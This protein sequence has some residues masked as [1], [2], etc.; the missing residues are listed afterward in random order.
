[1]NIRLAMLMSIAVMPAVAAAQAPAQTPAQKEAA[2]PQERMYGHQLMTDA[3]RAEYRAKMWAMKTNEER[4]AFRLEHHKKMQE[5][6]KKRGVT[7]P[8]S[9]PPRGMGQGMRQGPG[10][11]GQP[12][13][14]QR[15]N[16]PPK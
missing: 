9:P 14:G 8:D 3:E 11:G 16:P 1:M 15:G 13:S 7:L 5:R 10:A 6:A 2:A 12:R 4:E